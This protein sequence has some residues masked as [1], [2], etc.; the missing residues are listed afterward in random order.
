MSKLLILNRYFLFPP[1]QRWFH[2]VQIVSTKPTPL[3]GILRKYWKGR[4]ANLVNRNSSSTSTQGGSTPTE[5]KYNNSDF[6]TC[7][8]QIRSFFCVWVFYFI[9]MSTKIWIGC[10]NKKRRRK[11][12]MK[13]SSEMNTAR[14]LRSSFR[15]MVGCPEE[16]Q[17]SYWKHLK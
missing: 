16:H 14:L 10:F 5:Q 7:S 1:R 8:N 3:S 17:H 6:S 9:V 11:S 4:K 15:A 12:T 13:L 2:V